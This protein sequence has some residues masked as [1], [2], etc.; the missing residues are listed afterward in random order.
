MQLQQTQVD[1]KQEAGET[2][3][4][5]Q[6]DEDL[7]EETEKSEVETTESKSK[8]INRVNRELVEKLAE[9]LKN[10]WEKLAAKLGYTDEEVFYII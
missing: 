9:V 4:P 10:D 5:E 3:P 1:A 6:L 2:P 8:T 7:N